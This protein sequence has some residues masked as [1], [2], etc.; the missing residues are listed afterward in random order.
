MDCIDSKQ[1]VLLDIA[2]IMEKVNPMYRDE[3][4]V[5]FLVILAVA[6]MVIWETRKKGLYDGA[7]FYH[8]DQI[9]FFKHHLKFKIK[10]DRKR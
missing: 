3:K 9:L 7:N 5:A 10:C 8:C 4:C 2:Y 6:R 1:L